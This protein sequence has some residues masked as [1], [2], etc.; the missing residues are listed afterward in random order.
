MQWFVNSDHIVLS[1][2]D[3]DYRT[4]KEDGMNLVW[5]APPMGDVLASP[6]S[7]LV[8]RVE[9]KTLKLIRRELDDKP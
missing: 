8:L 3:F 1:R 9:G 7:E 5:I 2:L 4:F 6:G